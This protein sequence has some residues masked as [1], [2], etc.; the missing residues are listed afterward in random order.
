MFYLDII[1]QTLIDIILFRNLSLSLYFFIFIYCM[2]L[3][4]KKI[5]L[6][7][8]KSKF[9]L[10]C[11]LLIL[12]LVIPLFNNSFFKYEKLSFRTQNIGV[13][14]DN[15]L[16]VEKILNQSAIDISIYI[17]KV[18]NWA[19]DNS[20][21]LYWY[22]LDSSINKDDIIFNNETT[23][24]D[25]IKDISLN[26]EID[27]LL[28]ISDGAINS[29][30]ISNDFYDQNNLTIH[31]IGL[32]DL[33]TGQ[34]IGITDIRLEHLKDSIYLDVSFSAKMNK[35]KSFIYEIFSDNISLYSD[36]IKVS[37]GDYNFDKQF[38]FQSK[39][40]ANN[41]KSHITPVGF[42]DS[43]THNNYWEIDLAKNELKD[44][45]LISGKLSYNTSFIKSN[46][47]SISNINLKHTIVF[48]EG[49][50]YSSLL[51]DNF[52]CVIF[53]NFP[54]DI[55][56]YNF[57]K[58]TY[59]NELDIMFF[60]SYNFEPELL[61]MM[62]DYIAPQKFYIQS[63]DYQKKYKLGANFDLLSLKSNY[64]LFCNDCSNLNA[65]NSFSNS[66]I[67]ELSLSNFYAFLIPNISELSFFMKTKYDNSYID[68]YFKYLINKNLNTNPLLDLQL[69]KSN[70]SIGEKLLFE[71]NDN[72]PFDIIN[73][74]V[75]I[76]D[77]DRMTIDSI[78]YNSE[79]NFFFNKNGKFEIYFSF[80][81]TNSEVIN[82]NK[83]SFYIDKHNIEL[84]EI[85]QNMRL[86]K[87]ISSKS[88]G[89]YT[90]IDSLD[91]IFLDKINLNFIEQDLK[92]IYSTLE[93]FIKEKIF[94]LMIILFC[95]EI[96]LRKKIGLL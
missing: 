79:T 74:K 40:I 51:L 87:D 47:K 21:N 49:F 41:I 62:L 78:D 22:D 89:L 44:I 13:M 95:L 52:D 70:Y 71:L 8:N 6:K 94:L 14:F 83:K 20:I 34:D 55:N 59:K 35:D 63:G 26:N 77:L 16:S 58:N 53:D 28:L 39:V 60:E 84:E 1:F 85:A 25:Y 67:A 5:Q 65:I 46:L 19:D 2:Y 29:G 93:I 18:E 69:D 96:Y 72:I 15:S 36:S 33:D 12:I 24:F 3:L 32:G 90:N 54:N 81:G 68:E 75:V 82:S 42:S 37:S 91:Y 7:G 9:I 73:Q 23:S 64:N 31:S 48:D 66:S 38:Y 56:G 80:I 61:K 88:G 76:K 57:F 45:L 92:D 10:L 11:R 43:K 17:D 50:D 27:Q 86:L 30:F 4:S